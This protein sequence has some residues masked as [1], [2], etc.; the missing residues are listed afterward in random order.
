MDYRFKESALEALQEAAEAI[1][2]TEFDCK[3]LAY[4]YATI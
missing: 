3:L 4:I 2:I 1:L